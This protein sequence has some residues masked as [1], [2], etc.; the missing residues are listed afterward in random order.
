MVARTSLTLSMSTSDVN[1]IRAVTPYTPMIA[2][3]NLKSM[4]AAHRVKRAVCPC[5]TNAV[6]TIRTLPFCTWSLHFLHRAREV[7]A[8]P[9]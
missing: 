4:H 2:D 5:F 9:M 3:A 8:T 6:V 7:G 1:G